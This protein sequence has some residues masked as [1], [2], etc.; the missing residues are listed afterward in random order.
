M[1]YVSIIR[2]GERV[3]SNL[4]ADFGLVIAVRRVPRRDLRGA[5]VLGLRT[6]LAAARK[7]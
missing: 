1:R 2:Q 5:L 6:G 7:K 4:A 3:D